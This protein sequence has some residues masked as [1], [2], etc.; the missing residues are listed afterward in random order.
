MQE[1]W[2]FAEVCGKPEKPRRRG[3]AGG[4]WAVTQRGVR[5]GER[6]RSIFTYAFLLVC[7]IAHK[8][9]PTLKAPG[10]NIF[11]LPQICYSGK[12]G[13]FRGRKAKKKKSDRSFL[14]CSGPP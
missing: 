9:R 11:Y 13:V 4:D 7:A 8:T 2:V 14:G 5:K 12:T 6:W 1:G 10:P 3:L